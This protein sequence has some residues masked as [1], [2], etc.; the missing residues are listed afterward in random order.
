MLGDRRWGGL[1]GI[2]ADFVAEE[3]SKAVLVLASDF[4]VPAAQGVSKIAF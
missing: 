4:Q 1:Y 2:D 3:N